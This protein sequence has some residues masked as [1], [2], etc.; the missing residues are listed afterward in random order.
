MRAHGG[1]APAVA[2]VRGGGSE[3][4]LREPLRGLQAGQTLVL[5]RP[6]PA[7]DEVIGSAHHRG[8]NPE[9]AW[10]CSSSRSRTLNRATRRR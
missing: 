7:G 2:E 9:S 8:I 5:Y 3:V 4:T 10:R 1:V 6:D